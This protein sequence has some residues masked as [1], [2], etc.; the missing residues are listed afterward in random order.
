MKKSIFKLFL[1]F[2]FL[3]SFSAYSQYREKR[4]YR[5]W[6]NPYDVE[7]TATVMARKQA[8]RDANLALIEKYLE[9]INKGFSV[10]FQNQELDRFK[11]HSYYMQALY[12]MYNADLKK[13]NNQRLDL[14]SNSTS[15][16][17]IQHLKF[18]E[19][20]ITKV[21]KKMINND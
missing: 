19:N 3:L 10:F 13:I 8:N 1:F 16:Y 14:S 17:V 18:Y 2:F 5:E 21:F 9:R 6:V 11:P 12:E 4:Q 20:E 7:L 15:N